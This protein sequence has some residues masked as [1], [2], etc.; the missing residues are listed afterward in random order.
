MGPEQV[1]LIY[2]GHYK[3]QKARIKEL[4]AGIRYALDLLEDGL[5]EEAMFKLDRR[6]PGA[7]PKKAK[8][9]RKSDC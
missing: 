2:K 5:I 8:D 6:L 4:E 3:R 9:S 1:A 7:D